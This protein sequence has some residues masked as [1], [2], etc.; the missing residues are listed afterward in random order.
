MDSLTPLFTAAM[1]GD[2]V[3][4]NRLFAEVRPMLLVAAQPLL[5]DWLRQRI[6]LSDLVQETLANA[7]AALPQFRADNVAQFIA[8]LKSIQQNQAKTLI[9]FHKAK[10]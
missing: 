8:W 10:L 9:A 7:F 1:S 2:T 6:G 5:P 4:L 3:A